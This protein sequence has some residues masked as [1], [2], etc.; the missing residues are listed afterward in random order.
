M[1]TAADPA[2]RDVERTNN[3]WDMLDFRCGVKRS[4]QLTARIDGIDWNFLFWERSVSPARARL[5]LAF[6]AYTG[7]RELSA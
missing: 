4:S 7:T 2:K 5:P 1:S 6:G 3:E